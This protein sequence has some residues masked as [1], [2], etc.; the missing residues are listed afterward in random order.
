MR[1]MNSL[2]GA[3]CLIVSILVLIET[4]SCCGVNSTDDLL[5]NSLK[6]WTANHSCLAL[7][8]CS[9]RLALA[10]I[11]FSMPLMRPKLSAT[12]E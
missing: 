2:S 10:F 11:A 1:W 4:S 5:N 6:F 3:D 8:D 9:S 12:F 7:L